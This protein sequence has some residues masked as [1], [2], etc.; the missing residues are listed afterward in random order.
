MCGRFQLD[1][2][3]ET[4]EEMF[5]N[6]QVP[7]QEILQTG[8]LTPGR[9]ISLIGMREKFYS[10]DH[11]FWG[12]KQ[13]KGLQI[14]A[15]SERWKN[16]YSNYEPC[17]IPASGYYEWNQRTKAKMFFQGNSQS[18]FFLAGILA[19][20]EAGKREALIM[21]RDAEDS[22]V[23]IHPRM[24]VAF[25]LKNAKRYLTGLKEDPSQWQTVKDWTTD[26]CS[27]EQISFFE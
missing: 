5:E 2:S 8:E 27:P 17:L 11:A 22:I 9:T 14:N 7:E 15:R 25:D 4:L 1:V 3:L 24:P 20:D 16:L 13:E 18:L 19:V 12:R 10:L 26:L 23:K 21:T 6:L